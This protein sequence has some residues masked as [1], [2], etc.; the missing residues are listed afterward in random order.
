MA[1]PGG[2]NPGGLTFLAGLASTIYRLDMEA[3]G[4]FKDDF[5][6]VLDEELER[7]VVADEI[8]G[9]VAR[10]DVKAIRERLDQYFGM[11]KMF[12]ALDKEP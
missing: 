6:K 4:Q 10:A 7:A 11:E 3:T 8:N 1:R 5:L 9:R 12:S 2:M